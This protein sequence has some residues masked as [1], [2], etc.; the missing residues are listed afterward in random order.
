MYRSGALCYRDC[1]NIGLQNCGIGACASDGTVCAEK[2]VGMVQ[3]VFEGIATALSTIAT[4]GSSTAVKTGLKSGINAMG[5]VAINEVKNKVKKLLT[6][7]VTKRTILNKAKDILKDKIKSESK[8]WL[9][10]RLSDVFVTGVCGGVWEQSIKKLVATSTKDYDENNLLAAVD[11]FSIQGTVTSCQDTS[12]SAKAMDCGKAVVD[13]LSN[14]DPTGVLTIAGAFM[15]TVCDVTIK[16]YS[17]N[18]TAEEA[19]A[20]ETLKRIDVNDKTKFDPKCV[21]M[22]SQCNF[23]G[24][25]YKACVEGDL[26]A[27]NDKMNSA[28]V[29]MDLKDATFFEHMGSN[30]RFITFG[31]GNMIKCLK[32]Y[33]NSEV[34]L[35]GIKSA[36]KFNL[37]NCYFLNFRTSMKTYKEGSNRILCNDQEPNAKIAIRDDANIDNKLIVIKT[38]IKGQKITFYAEPNYKGK[39][40]T[41]DGS[42][43]YN[44]KS[45]F[46]FSTIG[47]YKI[48]RP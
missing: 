30:G 33:K 9:K 35:T 48:T 12:D 20:D 14:F 40:I 18:Q 27:F 15:H 44:N 28:Y 42:F 29:G 25:Y 11:V 10:G 6:T 19:Q 37:G 17:K 46:G 39:S 7:E 24:E 13:G 47:S 16:D 43:T 26:H 41:I 36:I 4:L 5:I 2:I 23:E 45:E 34:D 32:D 1:N 3:G 38:N 21:H 22:W 8:N 31:G